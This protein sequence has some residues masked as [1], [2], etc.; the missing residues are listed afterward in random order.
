MSFSEDNRQENRA[1]ATVKMGKWH[2][3]EFHRTFTQN[4]RMP[5]KITAHMRGPIDEES[6]T[7]ILSLQSLLKKEIPGTYPVT[8]IQRQTDKSDYLLT[9]GAD[10]TR[11]DMD[12]VERQLQEL[13]RDLGDAVLGITTTNNCATNYTT[14]RNARHTRFSR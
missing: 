14:G 10:F 12:S 2:S 4:A 13:K 7:T 1:Q 3:G 11:R 6:A 5:H 8:S 9:L